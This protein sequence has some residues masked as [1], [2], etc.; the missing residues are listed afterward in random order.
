MYK[1]IIFCSLT[2]LISISFAATS[3]FSQRNDSL[4]ITFDTAQQVYP[5]DASYESKEMTQIKH[6]MGILGV[7]KKEN[8]LILEKG[9]VIDADSFETNSRAGKYDDFTINILR[10]SASVR[11]YTN[12]KLIKIVIRVD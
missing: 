2:T 9:K 3:L 1:N 11:K 8:L 6:Q 12:N 10:D 5:I 7:K 4:H